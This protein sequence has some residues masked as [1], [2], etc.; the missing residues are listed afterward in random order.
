MATPALPPSPALPSTTEAFQ[1]L[2]T[3]DLH[4]HLQPESRRTL[5]DLMEDVLPFVDRLGIERL[6]P[7]LHVGLGTARTPA[8]FK[9]GYIQEVEDLLNRWPNQ[10]L[11]FVWL[12]A[13]K[14]PESL[15]ALDR[16]VRDGPMV[17]VKFGGGPIG[18]LRCNH[19]N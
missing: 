8:E 5:S 17:G 1:A 7:F 2:R 16:W 9:P 10:L 11:G 18:T 15:A 13:N 4:F 12:N 14:V 3:W 6:C 19:P